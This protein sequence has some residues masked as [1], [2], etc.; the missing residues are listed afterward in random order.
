MI[1]LHDDKMIGAK[2]DSIKLQPSMGFGKNFL[3]RK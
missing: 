1:R 3:G 2:N